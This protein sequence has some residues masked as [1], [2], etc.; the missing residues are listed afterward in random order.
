MIQQHQLQLCY[1][2]LLLIGNILVKLKLEVKFVNIT[3]LQQLMMEKVL[4]E[5]HMLI[6]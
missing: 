4:K 3:N 1:Q 6:K 2:I 5:I